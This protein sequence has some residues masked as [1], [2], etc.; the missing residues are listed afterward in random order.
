MGVWFLDVKLMVHFR[1]HV[2]V[3]NCKIVPEQ[4]GYEFMTLG[5][6]VLVINKQTN[7]HCELLDL[8]NKHISLCFSLYC[9]HFISL[10]S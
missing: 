1:V 3:S 10:F 6:I 2:I 9:S 8:K 4:P 5:Y 7:Q